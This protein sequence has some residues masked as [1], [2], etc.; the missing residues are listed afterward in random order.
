MATK[1]PTTEVKGAKA[2]VGWPVLPSE[3]NWSTVALWAVTISAGIAAWS[4]SIGGAV[5]WYL[6]AAV[7]TL[8]MLAGSFIGMYFVTM[9]AMPISVKYGVDTIAAS[10]ASFGVYGSAV[11]IVG[12][13]FSII[14]W[15]CLLIIILGRATAN[16]LVKAGVIDAS[17]AYR[18]TVIV[19][20]AVIVYCIYLVMGGSDSV[21][22][23][24]IWIA[25]GVVIAGIIVMAVLL[26]K[27]GGT[28]LD[29]KPAY[30]SGDKHLDLVLGTE[31]LAATVLSWWPYMGGV[32]RMGRSA[33]QAIWPCMFCLGA[34]TGIISCIG[35]YAGLA[36]GN[37]DPSVFFVDVLGLWMGI[38]AIIFIALANIGTAI[39]GVYAVIVG[40]RQIPVVERKLSYR[41]TGFIAFIPVIIIA[42]LFSTWYTEHILTFMYFLGLIF[43]PICGVQIV[44]NFV[45]RKHR[46]HLRSLYDNTNKSR[47]WFWGGVNWMAII[48]VAAGAYTYYF[49]LDP[50]TYE[51][52]PW[53][54]ILGASIPS[55][56]VAGI[57]F[58]IL[59][60]AISR[61]LKKGGYA[62]DAADKTIS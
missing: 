47:Y 41:W 6:P 43:G 3:R 36:T 60:W 8:A 52:H 33:K 22:D 4:Y 7:G 26:L 18:V 21:R 1:A 5:S 49:L 11:G 13:I 57:I 51:S 27:Q 37:S 28:I 40:L 42:G 29:A 38:I 2:D 54:K 17:W 61:P 55:V 39:V 56:L 58:W 45:F 16:V 24:S 14:G 53:F 44:D 10:K 30:S 46:L 20:L 35:L 12:Q 19:S 62:A 34:M 25:V 32:M 48:A 59:T 50:V 15:N 31:I 9:A 23:N